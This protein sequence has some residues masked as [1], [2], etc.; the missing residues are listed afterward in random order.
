VWCDLRT[1]QFCREIHVESQ[2]FCV[3]IATEYQACL[4]SGLVRHNLARV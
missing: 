2:G 1:A 4:V 3:M